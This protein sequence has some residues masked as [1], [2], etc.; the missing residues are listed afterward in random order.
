[1]GWRVKSNLKAWLITGAIVVTAIAIATTVVLVRKKAPQSLLPSHVLISEIQTLPTESNGTVADTI[2]LTDGEKINDVGYDLTQIG[3]IT[4]ASGQPIYLLKSFTCRNCEADIQLIILSPSLHQ[5][6]RLP[7][8]GEH[9]L[10]HEAVE[11]EVPDFVAEGRFGLCGSSEHRLYLATKR[12]DVDFDGMSVQ[13]GENWEYSFHALSFLDDGHISKNMEN[14]DGF[15]E[16]KRLEGSDC[17]S[18]E[19][20]DR[21][22]Y[23]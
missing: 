20:E 17:L 18:I 4:L 22:D 6:E 21:M 23:L 3:S 10:L 15:A 8:P 14:R 7:F 11:Q 13:I 16:L 5:I 1:M 2:V 19:P 12:R 9:L